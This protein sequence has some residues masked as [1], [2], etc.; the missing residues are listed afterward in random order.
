MADPEPGRPLWGWPVPNGKAPGMLWLFGETGWQNLQLYYETDQEV[1][2]NDKRAKQLFPEAEVTVLLF[3]SEWP[4]SRQS[5]RPN[6]DA[7]P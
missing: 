2:A 6:N 5:S 7:R 3:G 4:P 1:A